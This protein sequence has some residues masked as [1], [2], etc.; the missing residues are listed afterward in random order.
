[1][2][3]KAQA[4]LYSEDRVAPVPVSLRQKYFLEKSHQGERIFEVGPEL[5]QV[6]HFRRFNLKGENFRFT[7]PFDVIFCRNVMIYFNR[8]AQEAV[9]RRLS[10][11]LRQ[12]GYFFTGLSESLL[13]ITH[14]FKSVASSVY[15]KP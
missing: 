8:E 5:R 1:V 10:G 7:N 13:A 3:E 6:T 11:A 2:I 14:P 4:G 9:V 12:E 15:V